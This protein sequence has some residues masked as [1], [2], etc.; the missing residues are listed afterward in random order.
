M[1]TFARRSAVGFALSLLLAG[2]CADLM[3]Y[4]GDD[5]R[6]G[7]DLYQKSEYADATAAFLNATRQDPQDYL[8]F[9][10]LGASYQARGL[11]PQAITAYR[12]CLDVMPLSLAGQNDL[13]TW[14]HARDG[15]ATSIAKGPTYAAET[16]KLERSA[17]GK[18]SVEDQW[19][20]AK[21]HRAAG[22][23]DAAVDEYNKAVHID[24]TRFDV[25]K[26]AGLYE[27]GLKQTDLAEFTLKR[28]YGVDPNDND[29]NAA[30][31]QL[32]V[33][34]GPSLA[35]PSSLSHT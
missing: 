34:L 7:L 5:R 11:Y 24:P 18:G 17:A 21:I 31:R 15:L 1:S 3:T 4:A 28:A 16:A 2:G 32:G 19:L 33:V 13:P 25:L 26:E 27:Y 9:Y 22:D 29:V 8:S 6:Q 10:Y 23:A 20:L 12:S 14:Y 35:D 30:L